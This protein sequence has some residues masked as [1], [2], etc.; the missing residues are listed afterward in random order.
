MIQ[1]TV[2]RGDGVGRKLGYPTANIN[3]TP[4]Q[5]GL[6]AGIYAAYAM[7]AHERYRAALVIDEG[8]G[9]VEVHILDAGGDYYGMA[10]SVEPLTK[11]SEHVPIDSMD[12]LKQKIAKDITLVRRAFV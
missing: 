7:I 8:R 3:V 1:G 12:A 9:K 10:I 5:I 4:A 6:A 2:V 11:V